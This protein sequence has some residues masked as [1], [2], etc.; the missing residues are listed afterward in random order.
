VCA[1]EDLARRRHRRG[2]RFDGG[3]AS[4]SATI[5]IWQHLSARTN[6]VPMAERRDT[7]RISVT[8]HEAVEIEGGLVLPPGT[9]PGTRTRIG[10]VLGGR[11]S[12]TP[13]RY[14][15]QLTGLQ[16][17]DMG[18]PNTDHTVTIDFDVTPQ[19]NTGKLRAL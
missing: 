3:V 6:L 13:P 5:I 11:T 19:V 7:L 14:K 10:V 2:S 16:L 4:V 12:W 8:A 9:Y 15:I 18:V 1:H 17:A